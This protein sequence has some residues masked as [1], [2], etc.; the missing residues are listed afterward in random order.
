MPEWSEAACITAIDALVAIAR[1][2]YDHEKPILL[3]LCE[4]HSRLEP[5]DVRQYLRRGLEGLA[6]RFGYAYDC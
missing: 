2:S 4:T 1:Y 6:A 3:L 5:A